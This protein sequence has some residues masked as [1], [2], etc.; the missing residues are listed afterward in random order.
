MVH[1]NEGG[2]ARTYLISLFFTFTDKIG[3]RYVCHFIQKTVGVGR[4]GQQKSLRTGRDTDRYGTKWYT[5]WY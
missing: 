1:L 2:R 3:M 4:S 5:V